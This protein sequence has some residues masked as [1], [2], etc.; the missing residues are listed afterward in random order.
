MKIKNRQKTCQWH[1]G[2]PL[3]TEYHDKEWGVPVYN[4]KKIFEFLIL[5]GAQAG[6]SWKTILHK[7]DGYKKLFSGFDPNKVALFTSKD[8]IRILKNPAV[9]RNRLKIEAAVNNAKQFLKVKKEF[10]KFSNYI[11]KFVGNK[12]IDGKRKNLKDIP[13]KTKEAESLS[14]DL[15]KRGF[16]FVG[17]MIVY[18][19]MQAIGMVNDHIIDCFRYQEVKNRPTD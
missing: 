11:W 8:I 18:A 14:L 15:K 4:D 16:K 2:D 3:M 10:G 6:L 5:E 12:P 19:H 17:P 7:R 1:I 13:A 9:I